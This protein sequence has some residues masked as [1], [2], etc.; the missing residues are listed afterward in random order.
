[1]GSSCPAVCIPVLAQAPAS[2][3]HLQ[4]PT[5]LLTTQTCVSMS[6]LAWQLRMYGTQISG[7]ISQGFQFL[8]NWKILL[9]GDANSI[10]R[11]ERADKLPKWPLDIC[12]TQESH[13]T[14]W[15]SPTLNILQLCLPG[16]R[17]NVGKLEQDSELEYRCLLTA[18][19]TSSFPLPSQP[20][21]L[22]TNRQDQET[23]Q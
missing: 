2:H 15:I 21:Q 23:K 4:V 11:M 9:L 12:P 17:K 8:T 5:L 19:L 14:P 3:A 20:R 16:V 18:E 10:S 7:G 1:M 13:Q 6:T 22:A